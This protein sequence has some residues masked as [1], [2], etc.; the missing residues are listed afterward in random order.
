[1]STKVYRSTYDI[2]ITDNICLKDVFFCT[3]VWDNFFWVYTHYIPVEFI[4]YSQGN[5]KHLISNVWTSDDEKTQEANFGKVSYT[6][7]VTNVLYL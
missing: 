6:K 4:Q 7:T 2:M 3:W 1:M 5:L